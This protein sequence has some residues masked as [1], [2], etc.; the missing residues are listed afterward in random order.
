MECYVL[1]MFVALII[2]Q[3][4]LEYKSHQNFLL[5]E[6]NKVAAKHVHIVNK[7]EKNT[8]TFIDNAIMP[9]KA[10]FSSIIKMCAKNKDI[11]PGNV[12]NHDDDGN[13]LALPKHRTPEEI[14]ELRHQ[15]E[16][17]QKKAI[18]AVGL[19]E[20]NLREEDIARMTCPNCQLENVSAFWPPVTIKNRKNLLKTA[21]K[22]LQDQID[23]AS[24]E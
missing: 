15:Q 12:V 6:V 22:G 19:V 2:L 5:M 4:Y 23:G 11:H 20:D 24:F 18:T 17:A 21:E 13:P 9:P 14:K 1:Q 8:H 10:T 7:G 16:L 3:N